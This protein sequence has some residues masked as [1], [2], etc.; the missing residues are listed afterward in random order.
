MAFPLATCPCCGVQRADCDSDGFARAWEYHANQITVA[1]VD[2][3]MVE[4]AICQLRA[5][6]VAETH[7]HEAVL[8]WV[9][10]HT[11]GASTVLV[12]G[13]NTSCDEALASAARARLRVMPREIAAIETPVNWE[14]LQLRGLKPS[15]STTRRILE[16]PP[17]QQQ[18]YGARSCSRK[19]LQLSR[20]ARLDGREATLICLCR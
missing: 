10:L 17:A 11:S 15:C 18:V 4:E 6:G 12:M 9:S 19:P 7:V 8:G 1:H 13:E 14:I 2:F 20:Q 16:A 5:L 3:P